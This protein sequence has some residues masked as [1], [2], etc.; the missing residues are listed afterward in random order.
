MTLC[1]SSAQLTKHPGRSGPHGP[2]LST[3]RPQRFCGSP[4]DP[5]DFLALYWEA[6][7]GPVAS[8]KLLFLGK[9]HPQVM[10]P[11]SPGL[12]WPLP[13]REPDRGL[14][15]Q[16]PPHSLPEGPLPPSPPAASQGPA[17]CPGPSKAP[18]GPGR[19]SQ[20]RCPGHHVP[21]EERLLVR[22]VPGLTQRLCLPEGVDLTLGARNEAGL[23]LPLP[24]PGFS[25]LS[26]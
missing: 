8:V 19:P 5:S 23:A 12:N 21:L 9:P 25:L 14:Q 11:A 2:C 24:G 18:L 3:T 10:P 26:M 4:P 7:Q 17:W 20:V 16:L 15:L 13:R 6:S 1:L 22:N